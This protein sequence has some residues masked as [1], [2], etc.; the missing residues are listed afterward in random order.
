VKALAI[1]S[2]STPV[3]GNELQRAQRWHRL[4]RLP[5]PTVRRCSRWRTIV[6][7]CSS[8]AAAPPASHRPSGKHAAQISYPQSVSRA[9]RWND[10]SRGPLQGFDDV[11]IADLGEVVVEGSDRAKVAVLLETDEVVGFPTH[12][13]GCI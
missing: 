9:S 13:G 11:S 6:S 4:A 10:A 2:A 1:G 3:A 12:D 5:H 8:P 7:S